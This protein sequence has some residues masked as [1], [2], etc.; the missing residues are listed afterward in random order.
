[1]QEKKRRPRG[2]VLI[3]A[4]IFKVK[5]VLP[6]F[7]LGLAIILLM[8]G[9]SFCC[10]IVDVV[11]H[12]HGAAI[13]KMKIILLDF[14]DLVMVASLAKMIIAGSYNSFVTKDHGQPNEN[15]SSGMLK[16]KIS[17]S[18]LVVCSMDMLKHFVAGG[19]NF[20]KSCVSMQHSWWQH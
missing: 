4:V 18:I 10:E 3:E 8:Y 6:I 15:I 2:A 9:Y 12:Q 5:W 1:M 14:I 13:D 17:T 20:S 16:I 7:Y 19:M 11:I